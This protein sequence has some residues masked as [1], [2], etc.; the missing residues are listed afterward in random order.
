MVSVQDALDPR[1]LQVY[2][3]RLVAVRFTHFPYSSQVSLGV[4]E[5]ARMTKTR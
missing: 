3:S 4:P 1:R 2:P 5:L